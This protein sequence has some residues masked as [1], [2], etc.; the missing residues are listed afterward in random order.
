MNTVFLGT[1]PKCKSRSLDRS[2]G[3]TSVAKE[4]G[5]G[6]EGRRDQ[7]I[8]QHPVSSHALYLLLIKQFILVRPQAFL[9]FSKVGSC[10]GLTW[11]FF[12][13]GT[14]VTAVQGGPTRECFTLSLGLTPKYRFTEL[15]TVPLKEHLH[16]PAWVGAV[17]FISAGSG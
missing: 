11:P 13:V 14:C 5:G 7:E 8:S 17:A 16:F 3:K 6:A 9:K 15:C 12:H 2:P 1:E 4:V 10:Q